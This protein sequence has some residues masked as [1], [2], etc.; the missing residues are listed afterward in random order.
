LAVAIEFDAVVAPPARNLFIAE[1]LAPIAPPAEPEPK[2]EPALDPDARIRADVN[3]T[4]DSIDVI[5]FLSTG[6][7][8]VA[9][10]NMGGAVVNALKG[11]RPVPGYIVSEIATNS[12]TLTHVELGIKRT[13]GLNNV[14]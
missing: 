5:G 2:A 8:I 7:G 10:L 6:E 14:D 1:A 13:Y 11:D 12:V 3:R 9:V 4:L